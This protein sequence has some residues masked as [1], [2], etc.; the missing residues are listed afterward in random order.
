MA[1]KKRSM[2]PMLLCLSIR[3]LVE[4]LLVTLGEVVVV[5]DASFEF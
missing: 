1:A 2:T 4:V 3:E 5:C